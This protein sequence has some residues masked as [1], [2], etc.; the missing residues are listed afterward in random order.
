MLAL[1]FIYLKKELLVSDN[2]EIQML[3]VIVQRQLH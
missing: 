2:T 1:S 3:P